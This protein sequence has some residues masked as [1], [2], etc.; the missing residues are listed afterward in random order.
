MRTETAKKAPAAHYPAPYALIDL[1]ENHGG[2]PQ[3]MAKAEIASFARLMVTDTSRNLVRVFFLREKLKG[4]ADGDW[5]GQRVHVIGAGAMGGDIAAW[6]AWNGF[7]VTLADMKA[8]P[9]GKAIARAAELYGKIGH[10]SIDMRDALDRL[11]P[12]LRGRGRALRRPRDRGGAGDARAQA[13]GLCRD[14]AEDAAGRHPR[15]QHVEHSARGAAQRLAAARAVRRHAFLQSGLAHA[16]GRGGEPRSGLPDV[17]A[18]A[19]AFLG[20]IDRLPAPVKSAP[21]FLVNR[22]LTPYMLEAMVMLDEGIKRETIDAAA[23][24][25]GMPMGPIE[26]ADKVGLDICLHVA[27]MLK[28][29]LGRPM[30]DS[31]HGCARRSRTASSAARP[32]RASTS[33]R[34]AARSRIATP[35]SRPRR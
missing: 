17:L 4:L 32:A 14:R 30:P 24:A 2:D 27:E 7:T 33:G 19:R 34:T 8:E 22:A 16:A 28:A 23:V 35:R 9:L 26:L 20:R 29:D 1:W 10:K 18:K 12:D 6:C 5:A 15:H 31:P 13:E 11:I 3:D 25:F 21:G